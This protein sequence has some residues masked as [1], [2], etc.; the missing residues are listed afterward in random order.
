MAIVSMETDYSKFE[1]SS[2]SVE[3]NGGLIAIHVAVTKGGTTVDL[4]LSPAEALHFAGALNSAVLA[5]LTEDET[6][7]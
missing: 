4:H 6:E 5:Y 2:I 7:E 3:A 1:P